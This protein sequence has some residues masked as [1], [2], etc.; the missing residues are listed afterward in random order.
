MGAPAQRIIL[1]GAMG[2]GKSTLGRQLQRDL[3]L[4]A[5]SVGDAIRRALGQPD[6]PLG[7]SVRQHLPVDRLGLIN[8]IAPDLVR[9]VV[10]SLVAPLAKSG[11]VLDGYPRTEAE[12]DDAL[13][14][15][16]PTGAAWLCAPSNIRLARMQ[17]RARKSDSLEKFVLREQREHTQL[18][19]VAAALTL[20]GIPVAQ[21]DATATVSVIATRVIDA[22]ALIPRQLLSETIARSTDDFKPQIV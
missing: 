21:I 4:P 9:S 16:A 13:T 17:Q 10:D 8:D 14:R 7:L 6:S 18:P 12:V 22:L 19:R 15:I 11:F 2:V 20:G 5:V 3:L 1:I